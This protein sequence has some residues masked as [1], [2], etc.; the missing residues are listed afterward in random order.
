MIIKKS[1]VMVL[2]GLLF[3]ITVTAQKNDLVT[4]STKTIYG[5]I[6][7][8][9]ALSVNYDQRFKGEKGLGFRVGI[10]GITVLVA[11]VFTLP[12]GINYLQGSNGHYLELGTGLS[13]VTVYNGAEFFDARN[14]TVIGYFTVGYRYQPLKKGFTGRI[15]VSPLI[16]PGG[17]FP[18]YGGISAGIRL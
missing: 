18:I 11:G 12:V 3:I 10:G 6:G 16:T 9:G 17:F 4:G 15:F 8:P 5:E 14:S 7:G 1:C 2:T 13:G